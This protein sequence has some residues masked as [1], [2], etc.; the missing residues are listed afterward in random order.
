MRRQY[1]LADVEPNIETVVKV[2]KEEKID[3]V[4]GLLEFNHTLW[5]WVDA[6]H[7]MS[8][9]RN[10]Q[11][12]KLVEPFWNLLEFYGIKLTDEQKAEIF[13]NFIED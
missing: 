4:V 7:M 10:P 5:F 13:K 11:D 6:H 3:D 1:T 9:V 12:I 2:M 8:K